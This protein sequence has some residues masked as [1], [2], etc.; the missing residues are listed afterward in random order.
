MWS[1]LPHLTCTDYPHWFIVSDSTVTATDCVLCGLDLS[2]TFLACADLSCTECT[3]FVT[4]IFHLCTVPSSLIIPDLDINMHHLVSV[5]VVPHVIDLVTNSGRLHWL[6]GRHA[7]TLTDS[8]IVTDFILDL[9]YRILVLVPTSLTLVYTTVT[10]FFFWLA[11]LTCIYA[12]TCTDSSYCLCTVHAFVLCAAWVVVFY[13]GC[14]WLVTDICLSYWFCPPVLHRA[15]YVL[16]HWVPV[17][18]HST[19]TVI[20]HFI[21]VMLF[22]WSLTDLYLIH[23]LEYPHRSFNYYQ[24]PTDLY[25]HDILA[26]GYRSFI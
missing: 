5:C 19:V 4:H 25:L 7:S 10:D 16:V 1:L 6:Y 18:M 9:L 15:L 11:A 12:C 26:C 21:P 20:S 2:P 8:H 13:I 14:A 24:L 3:D 17:V 22:A 23:V